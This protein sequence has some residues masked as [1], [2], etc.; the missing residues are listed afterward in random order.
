[1]TSLEKQ[2]AVRSVLCDM[3][4]YGDGCPDCRFFD[5]GDETDGRYWCAI[6]DHKGRIPFGDGWD[7]TTAIDD[8]CR[9]EKERQTAKKPVD[10][11]ELKDFNLQVYAIRGD[12]PSCGAERL[13]S[14][15]GRYCPRCGQ[16]IDWEGE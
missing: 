1:M 13:V 5:P 14:T 8:G 16:A 11:R 6:R 4:G 12:C 9:R 15:N 7:M 3:C 2:N 10:R